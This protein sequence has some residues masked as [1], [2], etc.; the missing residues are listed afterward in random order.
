MHLSLRAFFPAL[1]LA[2]LAPPLHGQASEAFVGSETESYLRM[3]QV[4]GG[5]APYPWSIR[6]FSPRE[7]ERLLPV[8]SA[9]PWREHLPLRPD[10][11]S[12]L[13]VSLVRPQLR[14]VYNSAYPYG[15]NDGAVWAGRGLTTSLQAG[16]AARYGPVSL[17]LAP[18]VFWAENRDFRLQENG[19]EGEMAFANAYR[20][21]TLDYPQRFGEEAYF[22]VDPGQ[23]TLRMDAGWIATG[24]STANQHWGP[25]RHHPIILGSNGPG[26]LHVFLGTSRPVDVWA[27]KVHTRL[28]WGRLEQSAYGT[29]SPDSSRRL[30]TGLVGVFTP[31]GAPGIEIGAA[32]LFHAPWS[33]DGL[34]PGRLLLP[35]EALYKKD[36]ADPYDESDRRYHNQL[37]SVFFRAALPESGFE[38]YGEYGRD[39]HNW[40]LRDF[41]LEPDHSSA[42]VLGVSRAWPLSPTGVLALSG[43]VANGEASHLSRIRPQSRFYPHERT[44]QGHTHRGQLLG[45]PSIFGGG[46]ATVRMDH[47]HPGGRWALHWSRSLHQD[48]A[49]A[50]TPGTVVRTGSAEHGLGGE[51]M[52]LSRGWEVLAGASGVYHRRRYFRSDV[53]NLHGTL[54][55][56][57][58][59]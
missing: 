23:S 40:D 44:R 58:G 35:L 46:G 56:R 4:S 3:L 5:S 16:V 22:R 14:T 21:H 12:G 26:F 24:I 11:A 51:V 17:T 9:H 6:S 55:V 47:F 57:V 31:R 53:W 1:L 52:L 15:V 29:M 41:L 10:T 8:D 39:D 30:L 2:T 54:Q 32:R 19:R 42:Y 28:V 25:A 37:A 49:P 45:S 36:S 7:V 18:M 33:A 43:E 13:R 50:W 27:G 38:V 48:E 20:P 59:F 34:D